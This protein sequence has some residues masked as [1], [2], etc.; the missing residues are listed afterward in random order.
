[1]ISPTIVNP[2]DSRWDLI[3]WLGV[4]ISSAIK[5]GI[6]SATFYG[7]LQQREGG[8]SSERL[9]ERNKIIQEKFAH[10]SRGKISHPLFRPTSF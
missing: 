2:L 7:F 3:C 10:P 8:Y 9:N 5:P 1:M 4:V 6:E